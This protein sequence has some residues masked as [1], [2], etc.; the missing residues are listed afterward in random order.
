VL[1]SDGQWTQPDCPDTSGLRAREVRA[2]GSRRP[3]PVRDAQEVRRVEAGYGQDSDR[4]RSRS[5]GFDE[6]LVKPIDLRTLANIV[7]AAPKHA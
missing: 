6:H 4:A 2:P 5:A 7:A 1:A 3:E